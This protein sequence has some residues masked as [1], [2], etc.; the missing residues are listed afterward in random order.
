MLRKNETKRKVGIKWLMACLRLRN[1]L[2]Q[3]RVRALALSVARGRA[4]HGVDMS[5]SQAKRHENVL[6]LEKKLEHKAAP[7]ASSD[8]HKYTQ[9][10]M[11]IKCYAKNLPMPKP[12]QQQQQQQHMQ[13]K[14]KKKNEKQKKKK[15]EKQQQP[16]CAQT[17]RTNR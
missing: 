10:T 8:P 11:I 1:R 7:T 16:Q 13:T 14:H 2:G 12:Q 6:Q 17:M 3:R 15:K 9:L 4:G 5:L